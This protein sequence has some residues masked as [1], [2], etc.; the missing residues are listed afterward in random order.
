[1][2]INIELLIRF[3]NEQTN[4][5]ETEIVQSW[6]AE[7][8]I[9]E[10]ELKKLIEI[11]E[12][13]RLFENINSAED[14]LVVRE[15]LFAKE[16]KLPTRYILRFVA[17]VAILIALSGLLIHIYKIAN[18]SIVFS[19]YSNDILNITLPD[20]SHVYLNRNSKIVFSKSF[21]KK[22]EITIEGQVFFK[23][24][25]NEHIP[26]LVKALESNIKVLGTS[27]TVETKPHYVEVIV[28]SGRVAFYS[29]K[30][31]SDTLFL[32]T[33]DKGIF[34]QNSYCLEKMKNNDLNY[35]AWENHTLSF[36]NTPMTQVILDLERY[37]NVKIT[38]TDHSISK[39]SYT[40]E[41]KNQSL[42]EVLKEM[43]L[44]LNVKSKNI[45]QNVIIIS[46]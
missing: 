14:W 5:D 30:K 41:F 22:R 17:A 8:N 24:R 27:F 36:N 28:A 3:V 45:S 11:P 20:S 43:E 19:N 32:S 31:H 10:Q 7:N 2:E 21:D 38:I 29:T 9:N 23:V 34:Q 44:V 25:R 35:L 40:S 16:K 15:K 39:L 26:F 42:K 46:K 18:Q 37:Y 13:V 4:A 12:G 1:M 6:L 33:G